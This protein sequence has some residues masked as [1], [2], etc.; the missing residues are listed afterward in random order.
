MSCQLI[1]GGIPTLIVPNKL[2]KI[3]ETYDARTAGVQ[4]QCLNRLGH[5]QHVEI[6]LSGLVLKCYNSYSRLQ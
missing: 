5:V 4:I 2:G 1:D 3:A 6:I